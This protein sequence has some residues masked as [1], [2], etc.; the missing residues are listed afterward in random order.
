MRGTRILAAATSVAAASVF[1][2][3]LYH[4]LPMYPPSLG[5]PLTTAA[6][7]F[8]IALAL[9]HWIDRHMWPGIAQ[10]GFIVSA[11]GLGLWM[12]GGTLNALGRHPADIIARPQPGWG[13]FSVGLIPIGLAAIRS[14]LSLP[15]RLLLPLGGLLLLGEPLK[16]FLGERAGGVTVLVAF[17]GGWLAIG[18]LLLFETERHARRDQSSTGAR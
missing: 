10:F 13:L 14:R 4:S 1:W 16:Y 2:F 7:L 17:G 18:A 12:V 6:I 11:F 5:L 8:L 15:M 9:L 3:T